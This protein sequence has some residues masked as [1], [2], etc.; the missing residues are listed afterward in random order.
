MLTGYQVNANWVYWV[1]SDVLL[2]FLEETVMFLEI[3]SWEAF[4]EGS[5]S[6]SCLRSFMFISGPG[7]RS[8][9]GFGLIPAVCWLF[10]P[11]AEQED[12][13]VLTEARSPV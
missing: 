4:L 11:E 12:Q 9:G 1:N 7:Q 6:S 13:E 10:S 2:H 3:L 8:L 5:R